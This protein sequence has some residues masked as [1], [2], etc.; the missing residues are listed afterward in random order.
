LSYV[1]VL[2]VA[3][4]ITPT[5]LNITRRQTRPTLRSTE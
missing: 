2:L 3:F 4:T 5:L 1:K